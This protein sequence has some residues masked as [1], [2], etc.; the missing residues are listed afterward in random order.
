MAKRIPTDS[1]AKAAAPA[2]R[3]REAAVPVV[4]IGASAGGLE[5]LDQFLSNVAVDSG[6]AFVVVQHLDPTQ[7]G[8]MPEL[9]QRSTTLRV[10][11]VKDRVHVEPNCVYVIPPNKELALLRG[12]LRL[13]APVA[14]RGL[15]LPID[16]FLK[17]LADDRKE[18]AIGVLLSG[19][20][21][22]GTLGARAIKDKGGL[23]LVQDPAQARFDA[24]PRSA[25][26]AGLADI[27]APANELPLRIKAFVG[28]TPYLVRSKIVLDT[29]AQSSIERIILILR[30]HTGHDFSDYKKSTLYRRIE[31]RMAIHQIDGIATYA[32]YLQENTAEADLLFKEFLIGVTRFFRDTDVWEQLQN[33]ALPVL[34]ASRPPSA[35]LRVWVP[36][37]STGEEAY[38]LAMVIKEAMAAQQP[39]QRRTLQIFGTDLDRDAIERARAGLYPPSIAGDV[40]PERLRRFF[41]QEDNG[42]RVNKD[43]RE[44]VIFAVQNLVTDPPFTKLD[45]LSCRNLLIYLE[46]ELQRRLFPL[47]HYSL[48]RDGLLFLGNAETVG[49]SGDLFQSLP[50][51]ARLY[52]RSESALRPEPLIF[53]AARPAHLR[54]APME[55]VRD[56]TPRMPVNLQNLADQFLLQRCAPPAVLVNRDGD[57][58]YVSGRTGRYLEPAAGRANWNIFA[59][60][61]MGLRHELQGAFLKA[62]RERTDIQLTGL[63]VDTGSGN[64]TVDVAIHSITEPEGLRGTTM[65]LFMDVATPPT[66]KPRKVKRFGHASPEVLHAEELEAAIQEARDQLQGARE[67]AQSSQEELKSANEE[68]QSANEELQSTNEELTTSKEEMQSLNEELQTVN[69]ELQAKVDELSRANNDMKNLLNSTD[70]ATVFLDGELN[71]R[72][73]TT[74]ATKIIRLI[75]SDVGRPMTDITST[76]EYPDL[77]DDAREVL[78]TLVFRERQLTTADGRWFT[79]RIMP[80]RT[81]DNR[82]DGLVITF[83]DITVAKRLESELRRGHEALEQQMQKR[84]AELAQATERLERQAGTV[85]GSTGKGSSAQEEP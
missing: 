39:P 31:R 76:L 3:A 58:L 47:F 63:K 56:T 8:M 61:R 14:K 75:P 36:G 53:P 6:M 83:A 44:C 74:Q 70:I 71:V 50:G 82:I 25:I 9:L 48:N 80:Y 29:R 59:M 15:R 41:L 34:L 5:A 43:I 7:K 84:T 32:R 60:A 4:G 66:E 20:G 65:I 49:A 17:S 40:S 2:H 72:R 37:C 30:D 78:R 23:V 18:Q 67:E 26:E 54:G 16:T 45:V 69:A 81:M 68:L 21:S 42:F 46:P 33:E 62:Q 13:A 19:M 28:H 38:S 64:Q 24:M 10:L 85:K 22:D 12:V 27:I 52:R 73:F 11:Q 57:I 77:A 35:P 51:K 1:K 55:E 79:A